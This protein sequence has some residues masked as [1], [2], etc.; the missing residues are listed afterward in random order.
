MVTN[1]V[2]HAGSSLHPRPPIDDPAAELFCQRLLA[3]DPDARL[4]VRTDI[5]KFV[6]KLV[7]A[8]KAGCSGQA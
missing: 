3:I 7:R 2:K 5:G 4:C 1:D 6:S 8:I